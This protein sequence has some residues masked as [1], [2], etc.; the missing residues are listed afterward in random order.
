MAK[1]IALG[2]GIAS[3][4]Q[5]PQAVTAATA[6]A[7]MKEELKAEANEPKNITM[8]GAELVEIDKLIANSDQPRKVFK[9]EELAE[10]S[11]SIKENGIIQPLIAVEV[12]GTFELIAGERRLR[13]A[14]MAGLQKVPVVL[15]RVTEK[16]KMVMAIVENVQ[17][18]D[19]NCVEEAL[20]Y[21][22]LMD[23]YNLTQEEVAKKIGKE[24]STVANFLRL[25]KL[26]RSV[27]ELLQKEM[28][29]FGH[30]KILAAVKDKERAQRL[31]NEAVISRWSVRELEANIKKKAKAPKETESEKRELAERLDG[32]RDQLEKNTGFQFSVDAKKNG[33]GKIAIHFTNEAEFNDIYEYLLSR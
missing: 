22:Q 11:N 7:L 28:L 10:L 30:G 6:S 24:R 33:R 23:H 1:K 15:K 29:S 19:L 8:S 5:Q 32:L 4:I 16:E 13:A 2:K 18:S 27:I 21:F 26:P 31:A 17:R 14:K 12:D 20:A 3:L 25:L 9:E